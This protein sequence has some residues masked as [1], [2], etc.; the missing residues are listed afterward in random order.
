MALAAA[1]AVGHVRGLLERLGLADKRLLLAVSG[2]ADS[3]AL[4]YIVSR[5]IGFEGC[6]AVTVD[7]GFRAESALEAAAVGRYMRKLGIRHEVRRL[8]WGTGKG[9]AATQVP[10]I[11]RLEEVARQRRYAEIGDVCHKH[12]V[13]TVLTGHHAGDQAETFL[14]RFMRH[15]GIYGLS[16]M[17]LQVPLPF[18]RPTGEPAPV[19]VRPLLDLDKHALYEICKAHGIE[20]HEDASNRD[21]RIRRNLLRQA[22]G[23]AAGD[24]TSPFNSA[25][26][27]KVCKTMQGHREFINQNVARLVEKHSTVYTHL[28]MAELSTV[29]GS[30]GLPGWASNAALRERILVSVIGWVNCKDHPPELAQLRQLERTILDFYAKQH[31]SGT[32]SARA[33]TSA[34]GITMIPP[35]SSHGWLFC[36]QNPRASEIPLHSGDMALG[37]A[38]VW[39][40]RLLVSVRR[41]PE[42][43]IAESATWQVHPLHAAMQQWGDQ[44][45]EHRRALRA[46]RRPAEVLQAVLASQPA[47]S[48]KPASDAQPRLVFALGAPVAQLP[49]FLGL[50][51]TVRALQGT[52]LAAGEWVA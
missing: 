52:S 18:V 14:F 34:A 12:G 10:P 33:P 3:M 31:T 50:D 42:C 38:L 26:L 47:V 11:Q 2:G 45:S 30:H 25:S 22:I 23:E 39:D 29:A 21:T 28:G 43:A 41:T 36:R 15:S 13:H 16:G 8:E 6:M 48:V 17:P 37:A 40:R 1:Q 5:A 49:G 27:L 24:T 20:W 51:V 46:T 9:S 44:V 19:L 35:T 7:H 4:A 32:G